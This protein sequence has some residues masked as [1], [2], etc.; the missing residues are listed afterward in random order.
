MEI[1]QIRNDIRPDFAEIDDVA[2][3]LGV[4]AHRARA[5]ALV[6]V[7]RALL[8]GEREATEGG[9]FEEGLCGAHVD[10]DGV[11]VS[12]VTNERSASETSA[13]DG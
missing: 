10:C 11:R 13:E 12:L 7:V 8:G 2:A 5:V 9:A 3:V 6:E 1:R 4:S